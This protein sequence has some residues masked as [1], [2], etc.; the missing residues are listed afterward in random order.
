[1]PDY[2]SGATRWV[3]IKKSFA[4]SASPTPRAIVLAC[5]ECAAMFA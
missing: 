1:M 5:V 4:V 2:N 3:W